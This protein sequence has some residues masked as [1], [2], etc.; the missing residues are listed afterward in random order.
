[1]VLMNSFCTNASDSKMLIYA[2]FLL[3]GFEEVRRNSKDAPKL[4]TTNY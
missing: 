1:M 2:D 4:L 3:W